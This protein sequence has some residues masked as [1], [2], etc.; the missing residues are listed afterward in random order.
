MNMQNLMAQA[1]KLKKDIEQKQNK[2]DSTIFE[3]NTE[4]VK[5]EMTGKREIKNLKINTSILEDND[6]LEALEDMI[7]IAFNDVNKQIEKI[8]EKELGMYGSGLGGLM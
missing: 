1:N 2:I 4:F 5:L 8:T 7:K 3:G 6:D